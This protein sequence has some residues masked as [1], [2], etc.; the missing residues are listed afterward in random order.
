MVRFIIIFLLFSTLAF[1]QKTETYTRG[2]EGIE[3]MG[4]VGDSTLIYSNHK[5]KGTIRHE[6]CDTI[7]RRYLNKK[8]P[9]K[10]LVLNI[11]KAKVTGT[12]KVIRKDKLILLDFH[13]EMVEW[14]DSI[15]EK[16]VPIIKNKKKIVK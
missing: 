8:I 15:T 12:L 13:Y 9:S 5:A 6:V 16:V 1:G 14:K 3:G 10:K 4:K 7:V 11:K 2:Y